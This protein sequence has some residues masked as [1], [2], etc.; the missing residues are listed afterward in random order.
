MTTPRRPLRVVFIGWGAISRSAAQLLKDVPV[1]IVAVA[2][3]AKIARHDL[4]PT[5]RRNKQPDELATIDADLVVEAASRESVA[6]WG[7]AA[8]GAGMDFVVS[9]VSAFADAELLAELRDVA[10]Q[11]AAQLE[12]QAGA[13]GG[14]D[15]LS[16]ASALGIDTVEH[17]IVKPPHAWSDTPAEHL[18]DLERLTESNAFFTGSAAEAASEFPKN[19]NVAMTTALAGI[20]PDRTRI[21]LVADPA[22]TTNR[23]EISASGAFGELAVTMSNKPLE[24]NPKTSAMTALNLVRAIQNRVSPLVI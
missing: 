3:R 19:A 6:Q 11:N 22:A 5:A 21:T 20:G 12:I 17:R 4:P 16:A 2:V 9:S 10:A 15:A 18:C 23:H 14:V 1:E 13:L 24:A 7:R 8:L